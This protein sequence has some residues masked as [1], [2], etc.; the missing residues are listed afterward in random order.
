MSSHLGRACSG[1]CMEE[2][3]ITNRGKQPPQKRTSTNSIVHNL[4]V[5]GKKQPEMVFSVQRNKDKTSRFEKQPN[6]NN[7]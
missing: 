6:I 7:Q 1:V 3:N 5:T 2:S 4:R